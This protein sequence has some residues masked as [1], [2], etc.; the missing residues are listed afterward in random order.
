MTFR[1]KKRAYEL[2][3]YEAALES[4]IDGS[5][6]FSN[7]PKDYDPDVVLRAAIAEVCAYR[8]GDTVTLPQKILF[9]DAGTSLSTRVFV[10]DLT[11]SCVSEE[12]LVPGVPSL[13]AGIIEGLILKHDPAAVVVNGKYLGKNAAD[14]LSSLVK[15]G[16]S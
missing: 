10:F 1:P 3:E 8:N 13:C 4:F 5:A 7:P 9:I 11:E 12:I 2:P 15:R 14:K 16:V 6:K